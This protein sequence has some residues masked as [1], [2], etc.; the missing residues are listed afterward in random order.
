M[1]FNQAETVMY[2]G[3]YYDKTTTHNTSSSVIAFN[4]SDGQALEQYD[5]YLLDLYCIGLSLEENYLYVAG[6][7]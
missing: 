5:F 6:T 1:K 7:I 2:L 4:T 3:I